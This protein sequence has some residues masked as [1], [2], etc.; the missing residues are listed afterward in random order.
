MRY[1]ITLGQAVHRDVHRIAAPISG[2]PPTER[3]KW[4]QVLHIA[5]DIVDVTFVRGPQSKTWSCDEVEIGGGVATL[6]QSGEIV[7][8]R[9]SDRREVV[10]PNGI[11]MPSWLQLVLDE[12]IKELP[13]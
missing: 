3:E 6:N 11:G 4:G 12:L 9:L 10:Y 1:E 5:P 13:R 7:S 2:A 8:V